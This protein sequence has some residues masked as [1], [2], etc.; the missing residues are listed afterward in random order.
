M[1]RY[2]IALGS[3]HPR[4]YIFFRQLETLF[5]NNSKY[6]LQAKSATYK[7]VSK[8]THYNCL[9]FNS[10]FALSTRLHPRLFHRE[11]LHLEHKFGRIR[12][13]QNGRRSID[14]DIILALGL[15]YKSSSLL[16]PHKEA[17][18]RNFFVIP[19]LEAL[20]LA[21]WPIPEKLLRAK[22]RLGCGRLFPFFG[23]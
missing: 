4:G 13:L 11:M 9:F 12:T 8:N 23:L 17:F 22:R 10:V 18:G 2:L 16:I 7:N 19:C 5:L 20:Q 1:N 15:S 21:R 3:S 6:A 14:I